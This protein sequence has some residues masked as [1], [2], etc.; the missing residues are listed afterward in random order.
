MEEILENKDKNLPLNDPTETLSLK[1][2]Q[3]WINYGVISVVKQ[4]VKTEVGSRLLLA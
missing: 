4:F 3:S 2:F 1:E